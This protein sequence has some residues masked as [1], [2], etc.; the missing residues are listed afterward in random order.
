MS[1]DC[2]TEHQQSARVVVKRT[3]VMLLAGV[4]IAAQQLGET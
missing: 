1:Q 4:A 3:S 2:S